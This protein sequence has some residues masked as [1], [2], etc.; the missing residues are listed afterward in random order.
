MKKKALSKEEI[1]DRE[2]GKNFVL[3]I[4]GILLLFTSISLVLGKKDPVVRH[5]SYAPWHFYCGVAMAFPTFGKIVCLET[6]LI[7]ME[8]EEAYKRQGKD[9]ANQ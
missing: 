8:M 2:L 3:V 4:F 1:E 7:I 6:S 9:N 5:T